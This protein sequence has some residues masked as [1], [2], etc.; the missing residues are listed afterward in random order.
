MARRG[1]SK[2]AYGWSERRYFTGGALAFRP[3]PRSRMNACQCRT[4]DYR[5]R[6]ITRLFRIV[7]DRRD[8]HWLASIL[9][10]RDADA[11][12]MPHSSTAVLA[13]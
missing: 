1:N 5:P 8:F 6:D 4:A 10:M 9:H 3:A 7:A 13:G 11:K 12:P 2:R